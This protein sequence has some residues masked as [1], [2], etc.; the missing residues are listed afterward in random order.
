MVN[1][2]LLHYDARM[3]VK[4]YSDAHVVKMT[5]E[6]CQILSS[7]LYWWNL[8][9]AAKYQHPDKLWKFAYIKHPVVFWAQAATHNAKTVCE[10]GNAL[11]RE[12]NR[13]YG[14]VHDANASIQIAVHIIMN[15]VT[16]SDALGDDHPCKLRPWIL[17]CK[18]LLDA[19]TML[20]GDA[21]AKRLGRKVAPFTLEGEYDNAC[22]CA[23][24]LHVHG[25]TKQQDKVLTDTLYH[26]L[27][28]IYETAIR[29]GAN[30]CKSQI[31][32]LF[33]RLY[34]CCK[35]YLGTGQQRKQLAFWGFE[36][37]IPSELGLQPL[38]CVI[39]H[40]FLPNDVPPLPADPADNAPRR[41]PS[42]KCRIPLLKWLVPMMHPS[43]I[44]SY[45]SSDD[46][47]SDSEE[48]NS[49]PN[50]FA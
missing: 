23:F 22:I 15:A 32:I 9:K 43:M 1:L 6:T 33:H 7:I 50:A 48:E 20:H 36:N 38:P 42:S 19:A 4:M 39:E 8:Y 10:Y 11:L 28:S 16:K 14:R 46:A 31:G 17:N 41:L 29:R 37:T 35:I 47:T 21:Y 3:S 27:N 34:Y 5:A 12:Y 18:D 25:N 49:V 30:N 40:V 2:F 13:R 26:F 45:E 44:L 24:S